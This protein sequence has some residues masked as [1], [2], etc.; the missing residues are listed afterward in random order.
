MSDIAQG[1][2]S[3]MLMSKFFCIRSRASTM[4]W[5]VLW[6]DVYDVSIR[7][8]SGWLHEWG[9]HLSSTIGDYLCSDLYCGRSQ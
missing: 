6:G 5:R 8:G 9:D 2:Y 4:G 3:P 1:V 7:D